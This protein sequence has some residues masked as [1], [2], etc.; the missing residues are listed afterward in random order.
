MARGIRVVLGD[1]TLNYGILCKELLTKLGFEVLITSRDSSE[2]FNVVKE[3][4]PHIVIME[5]FM[6][7]NNAI[8]V[9]NSV[10][11][12]YTTNNPYFIIISSFEDA[13]FEKNAIE[14]GASEFILKPF[15]ANYLCYKVLDLAKDIIVDEPDLIKKSYHPQIMIKEL[16]HEM[17]VPVQLGGYRF[18]VKAILL[19]IEDEEI[20]HMVTKKLYPS[21]AEFYNTTPARVE[22]SIRHAITSTWEKGN[23]DLLYKYFISK[24]KPTNSEFIALISEKIKLHISKHNFA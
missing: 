24:R 9:M 18:L 5:A 19:N 16:L 2:I 23:I 21:I 17:G 3:Y 8:D 22:R 20:I 7:N 13:Y 4:K 11:Y 10:K 15:D 1:N 12:F 14:N 6:K